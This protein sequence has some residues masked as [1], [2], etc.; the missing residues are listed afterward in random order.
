VHA[1]KGVAVPYDDDEPRLPVKFGPVSNGEFLP[2]AHTPV[3]R[4]AIRRAHDMADTNARRLGMSRRRF[5]TTM[6]GAAVTW[7]ALSACSNEAN[8]ANG[9]GSGGSLTIPPES[10]IDQDAAAETLSGQEFIMDVQTHLLDADLSVPIAGSGF[11]GGSFPFASCEAGKEAGDPRVCF[12]LDSYLNEMFLRSD[13]TVAVL[14]ALPVPG[15]AGPL[16]LP[17]MQE[18]RRTVEMLCG[19]GRV[20]MHGGAY[21]HVGPIDTALAAMTEAREDYDIAAWKIYTMVPRD[22][23][24]YFDDH[25]PTKPQIGQS[26]IDHVREIGPPIICTHKGISSIVGS[27]PELC[28]PVDIGP[29]AARNPDIDFVV[30]HSGFEPGQDEGPYTPE[31]RDLGTNRLIASLEDAGIGPNE[32]VYAELGGTWWFAMQ[33]PAA[34]APH[35]LG[36]LLKYVGEDNVVWGTDSIWFGTPQDQIQA[37]RTFEISEEYQERF[38][39][40]A[41]TP[42]I[43]AKI[44][45]LNSAR[46]YGVDPEIVP[47]EFTP[48]ELEAARATM[49]APRT[50]GPET[51]PAAARLIAAHQGLLI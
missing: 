22:A 6:S 32:N 43:K 39:Y 3:V 49:P 42:E 23:A 46:L 47:C 31:T 19:D 1:P 8:Q 51:A 35:V 29:A 36:K 34:T 9:D 30:Y 15:D 33:D 13:T 50:Y 37:L 24:F 17:V 45:G 7:F 44:F 18:T 4:E 12:T 16:S 14:S 10:T 11:I 38:G 20:L 27:T 40:P 2:L 25:D 41:L 48:E 21:P 26:F 5:L 28:S